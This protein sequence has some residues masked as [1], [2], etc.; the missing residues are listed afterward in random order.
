MDISLPEHVALYS[1]VTG[2]P[3]ES[4]AEMRA[5]L[6]RQVVEPVAWE[7]GMKNLIAMGVTRIYET[8]PGMQ[9]RAMLKRIDTAAY[10]TAS[11]MQ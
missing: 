1:N 10:D 11:V 7:A 2:K 6:K 3:Y 4:V 5:L 8:G 9:L